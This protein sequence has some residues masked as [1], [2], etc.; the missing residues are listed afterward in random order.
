MFSIERI[1]TIGVMLTCGAFMLYIADIVLCL[2]CDARPFGQ[3]IVPPGTVEVHVPGRYGSSVAYLTPQLA[4]V[5]Y[6]LL[7][8][9]VASI[10]VV[11]IGGMH[12]LGT[13]DIE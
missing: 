3:Q 10:V 1:K 4:T 11:V 8:I 6:W 2:V 13:G 5:H 7:G 12:Y 9:A